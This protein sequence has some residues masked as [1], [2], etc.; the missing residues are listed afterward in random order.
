MKT[1]LRHRRQASVK[2]RSGHRRPESILAKAFHRTVPLQ[3]TR[4][5]ALNTGYL[6]VW[7]VCAFKPW[8]RAGMMWQSTRD[9]MLFSVPMARLPSTT[10]H[11]VRSSKLDELCWSKYSNLQ[12]VKKT[13]VIK[14]HF[15][16]HKMPREKDELGGSGCMQKLT[17][18]QHQGRSDWPSACYFRWQHSSCHWSQTN[19]QDTKCGMLDKTLM[20]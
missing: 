4:D 1:V 10:E 9:L 6:H 14:Q 11:S 8:R 19:A 17:S 7:E 18:A 13:C 16:G 15:I 3:V 12:P 5:V 2:I 20:Q